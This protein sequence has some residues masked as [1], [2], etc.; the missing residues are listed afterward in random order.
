MLIPESQRRVKTVL[1]SNPLTAEQAV[2]AALDYIGE[3]DE[4]EFGAIDV[5]VIYDILRRVPAITV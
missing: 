5:E 2:A 3:P 4:L 1:T